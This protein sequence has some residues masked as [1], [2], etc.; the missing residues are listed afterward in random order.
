MQ[1]G[2]DKH[3]KMIGWNGVRIVIPAR[4]E[5]LV[6]APCHLVF[7][8]EFLPILQLRWDTIRKS[9]KDLLQITAAF[10]ERAETIIPAGELTPEWRLLE[11]R[12][13]IL[14]CSGDKE[15]TPTGGLFCCPHC[16][17]LF[18][19]QVFPNHTPVATL[20][21]DC[22]AT[23]SCHGHA[24][25]LWRIQDFSLI[26]P[27]PF[28]FTDCSF[29][30]GLTRL[31]FRAG[32][33]TLDTCTLAPADVRL[34]RQS[35]AEMLLALTATPDLEIQ[36]TDNHQSIEGFRSPG[37]AGRMLLRMRRCK[38]YVRA[39]IWHDL[40]HNRLLALVLTGSRPIP[41]DILPTLAGS[42]A[43]V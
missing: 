31:S 29:M 43:I 15:G 39:R 26:T 9:P 28:C 38:P 6:N 14:A 25:A 4:W 20:V 11:A 23:L 21:S 27:Q 5:T 41:D 36:E 10:A 40:P 13:Q 33:L 17:T 12:F 3:T 16:H 30:A 32:H 37:L 7:E 24:E 18:Q 22:L 1:A 42:Y 19:F 8:D 35:L 34:S 2:G